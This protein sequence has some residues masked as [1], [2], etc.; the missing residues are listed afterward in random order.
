M[1]PVL[2]MSRFNNIFGVLISIICIVALLVLDLKKIN[3]GE[4]EVEHFRCHYRFYCSILMLN[5][6]IVLC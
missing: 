5:V 1:I 4:L 2:V 6:L 3:D